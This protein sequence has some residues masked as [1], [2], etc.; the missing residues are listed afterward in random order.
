[1]RLLTIQYL[2]GFAAS[3]IVLHHALAHPLAIGLYTVGFGQV[4]VDIFFV[5]SGL[6]MWITTAD[7]RFATPWTF[8]LARIV[9]IVPLYWLMTFA[10]IAAAI[11]VPSQVFHGE[12][13]PSYVIRSLLFIPATSPSGLNVPIYS[14]GWTLNYEMFFY[15]VF[16]VCLLATSHV[17]RLISLGVVLVALSIAGLWLKPEHVVAATY[18]DPIMLEFF[19]GVLLG[20]IYLR[21][22]HLRAP[23]MLGWI[24]I[25]AAIVVFVWLLRFSIPRLFGFGLPALLAVA[26]ALVLE[27]RPAQTEIRL[28]RWLGDASYS[29]YLAHPFVLR[30]FYIVAALAIPMPSPLAQLSLVGLAILTGVVG[31]VACFALIERPMSR[32]AKTVHKLRTR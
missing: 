23:A 30:P 1:M 27:L 13:S 8:W 7:R 16:G 25:L 22:R 12:M 26:G 2:R 18:T 11:A 17:V 28:L 32:V 24:M 14:L 29:I 19:G 15:A 10:F 31:G 20:A 9:R 6:I 4:G 21:Y 3:L 5:I